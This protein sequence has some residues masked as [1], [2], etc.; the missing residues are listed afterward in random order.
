MNQENNL[1]TSNNV[2]GTPEADK[3]GTRLIKISLVLLVISMF[4]PMIKKNEDKIIGF[5]GT[6]EKRWPPKCAN[7]GVKSYAPNVDRVEIE[8]KPCFGDL[9]SLPMNMEPFNFYMEDGPAMIWFEGD[10]EPI[11]LLSDSEC[12]KRQ[13]ENCNNLGQ[14]G[15]WFRRA[16]FRLAGVKKIFFTRGDK[17]NPIGPSVTFE[18]DGKN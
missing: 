9:I 2:T 13:I 6:E 3:F 18:K 7:A 17:P 15:T 8:M 12:Q 5:L 4:W 16:R 1:K 11:A 10:K 14:K